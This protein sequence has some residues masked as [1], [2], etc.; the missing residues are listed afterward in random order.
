MRLYYAETP[1]ARRPCAVARHLNSPVKFVRIDFGRQEHTTPEFLAVN[2]NGKVPA[3]EDGDVKLWESNA[4][5][6]YLADKAGS[7]LW[8]KDARQ[9]DVVRWLSWDMAHFSR[10]GGALFFQ[11]HIKAVYGLGDPDAAAIEEATGFFKRFAGV[12]DD[13]L[14]GR[15]FLVGN[16]LS[17]AD[18][19]V[20]AVLPTAKEAK[21]PLDDF[22]EI[23][24]WHDRLCQLPAWQAPF[25][26]RA[27][28]AA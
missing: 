6:C 1:N 10:H 26:E 11:N 5:M 14:R 22:S 4:I 9:I 25:P 16:S 28:N 3:L 15:D 21:L 19:G 24:R 12:L 7:D 18:F 17:V 2:P 8:P 23:Q 13:H 27:A 20:A